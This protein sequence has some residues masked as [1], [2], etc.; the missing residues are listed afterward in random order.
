MD[1][2]LARRFHRNPYFGQFMAGL[3]NLISYD[4]KIAGSPTPET[5]KYLNDLM[6]VLAGGMWE[7]DDRASVSMPKVDG[8]R[9]SNPNNPF[10]SFSHAQSNQ[11]SLSM[12][13]SI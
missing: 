6:A 10:K 12:V 8:K 2:Q 11:E 1:S 7:A 13:Y 9:M 5:I 4:L 3:H